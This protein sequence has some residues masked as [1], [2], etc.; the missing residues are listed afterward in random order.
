M[1]YVVR[2]LLEIQNEASERISHAL[3]PLNKAT[4]PFY[5]QTLRDYAKAL[6]EQFPGAG[7]V[8]DKLAEYSDQ[9]VIVVN[10]E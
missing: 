6:E 5:I 1:D 9:H 4:A 8:A 3:N 7:E 10:R 2:Q